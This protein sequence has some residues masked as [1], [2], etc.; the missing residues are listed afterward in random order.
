MVI[1]FEMINDM[2]F[3]YLSEKCVKDELDKAK[4][5]RSQIKESIDWLSYMLARSEHPLS[6]EELQKEIKDATR[7]YN[8]INK[9]IESIELSSI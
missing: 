5:I 8:S 7:Q 2:F 3:S 4:E 6:Y 9:K 1:S